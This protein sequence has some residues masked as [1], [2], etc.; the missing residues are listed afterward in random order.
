M[1]GGGAAVT[2][3]TVPIYL[4]RV[5]VPPVPSADKPQN[6][7]CG[8]RVNQRYSLLTGRKMLGEA[9]DLAR[10]RAADTYSR[11]RWHSAKPQDE[12]TD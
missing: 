6:R 1:G 5:L 4:L 7:G 12:T 2:T 9:I 3:S 11:P 8:L 10:Y